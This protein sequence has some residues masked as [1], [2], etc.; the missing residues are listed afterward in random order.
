MKFVVLPE[1]GAGTGPGISEKGVC[2]E[3]E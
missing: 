2:H 1:A 3:K